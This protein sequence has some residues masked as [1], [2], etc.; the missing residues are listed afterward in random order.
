[1]RGQIP[2]RQ[3]RSNVLFRRIQMIGF[4]NADTP[5]DP[6]EGRCLGNIMARVTAAPAAKRWA[7]VPVTRPMVDSRRWRRQRAD[8]RPGRDFVRGVSDGWSA[9]HYSYSSS[10]CRP[11]RR[12]RSTPKGDSS[13]RKAN[14]PINT[15]SV[16]QSIG[17]SHSTMPSRSGTQ[18]PLHQSK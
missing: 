11:S 2:V 3:I 15:L 18:R 17:V 6:G 9:N 5:A 1:M 13:H 16:R 4:V 8:A 7:T 14:P 12:V 10:S